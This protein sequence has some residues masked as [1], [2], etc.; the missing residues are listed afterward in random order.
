MRYEYNKEIFT[1]EIMDQ[2]EAPHNTDSFLCLF[3]KEE[4]VSRNYLQ[5]EHLQEIISWKSGKKNLQ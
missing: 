1:R 4:I 5:S 2:W 3:N